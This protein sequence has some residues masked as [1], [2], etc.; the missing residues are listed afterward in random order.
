M[1]ALERPC[2]IS[3]STSRSRGVSRE[4]GRSSPELRC[5][6]WEMTWGSMAVP[7]AATRRTASVNCPASSTRS[8]SR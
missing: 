7:P 3:S 1:A 4:T 8:F 6:S 2:A 5:S